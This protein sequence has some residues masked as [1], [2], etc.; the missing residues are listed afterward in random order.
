MKRGCY[1]GLLLLVCAVSGCL[2]G[3]GVYGATNH[4]REIEKQDAKDNTLLREEYDSVFFVGEEENS[5]Y[6]QA[7]T[8]TEPLV[9][10][11]TP[12]PSQLPI[13]VQET[14]SSH[15]VKPTLVPEKAANQS[16][17]SMPAPTSAPS[18]LPSPTPGKLPTLMVVLPSIAPA[19][20]VAESIPT[21]PKPTATVPPV[22]TE[23]VSETKT[24]ITYPSEIFGQ[25]PVVNR[26]DSYVT[27][28]EFALDLITTLEPEIK[29]EGKNEM[30]LF[31]EFMLKALFCGI[32]VQSVK[33]N[34]PV[35]RD[36][37]AL[38]VHLAAQVLNK[39][40]TGTS[41]SSAQM[42]ASD[43]NNCSAAE[44]KA[45]AYLYEQ[46]MLKASQEKKFYPDTA[47]SEK[48]GAA[49]MARAGQVWQ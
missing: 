33:L 13:D 1:E 47:L 22:I 24:V 36:V 39:P 17:T 10:K 14:A 8:P 15:A 31:T 19:S 27:Y 37:A 26:E 25:T 30:A 3:Y 44:K 7:P 4:Q 9:H 41:T 21:E 5:V 49:W 28:F 18:A 23:Q 32:D 34:D 35:P 45:I 16:T 2:L 42:Y 40:G 29:R 43:V 11:E 48:E 20:G 12:I 38:A 6:G 46:G